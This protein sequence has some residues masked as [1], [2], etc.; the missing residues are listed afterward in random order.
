MR[1]LQNRVDPFGDLFADKS[2]G[3]FMGNRGGRIHSEAQNTRHA[4]L[5]VEAVDLLRARI[6][7]P[8]PQG[9]GRQLHRAV[10]PRRADGARGRPPPLLRMPPQGCRAVCESLGEVVQAQGASACG[11]DG[12][13]AANRTARRTREAPSPARF[14]RSAGWR[15]RCTPTMLRGWCAAVRCCAGR[16]QATPSGS[17]SRA[18]GVADVLTPPAT[19]AV[20]S[21]GYE[22]R[23]HPSAGR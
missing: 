3:L 11:G 16:R 18:R 6:Q 22:P 15:I 17:P 20:L 5:G 2:R 9:L 23:W 21:A 14:R 10:L 1:P 4:A 13:R 12:Q 8:A 19:L 7:Q